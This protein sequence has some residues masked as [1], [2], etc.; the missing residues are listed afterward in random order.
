MIAKTILE[1]HVITAKN[2]MGRGLWGIVWLMLY[3]PTPRSF[4][5]WRRMLLRLFGAR[6]GRGAHPYQSA[7]IW[8]PWNLE[9]GDHS[10]LSEWVD[11]YC[12]AKIKIGANA[13]V[14]QYSFLCSASHDYTDSCMPLICGPITIGDR[15]WVAAD[16]FIG[17]GT[18]IGEGSVVGARST[19]LR[20]VQPWTVVI[21]NPA[22]VLKTRVLS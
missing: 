13:T 1:R 9:M 19:V 20:D 21:G 2:R 7:R 17:P 4:H 22:R 18:T 8:A 14:S 16:A 3:R 12:V 10:C 15:A 6:I 11:C 5:A